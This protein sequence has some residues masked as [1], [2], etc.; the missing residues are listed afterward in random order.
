[1]YACEV[2]PFFLFLFCEYTIGEGVYIN[3]H[4]VPRAFE[5]LP[6]WIEVKEFNQLSYT[7]LAIYY[8][9]LVNEGL[10]S[11]FVA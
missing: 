8:L 2:S 6:I 1:M 11:Y 4:W 10:I 9:F 3:I 7:L 5:P